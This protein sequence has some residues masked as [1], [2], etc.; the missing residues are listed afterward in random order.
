MKFLFISL[1]TALVGMGNLANA[2]S[3]L[4]SEAVV[5]TDRT[6]ARLIA[7]APNGIQ[8]GADVRVGLLLKH[9]PEWHTYWK[10]SGES[11]LPTEISW[12]LPAGSSAGPLQ[13]PTPK[14]FKLGPLGNYG[15]D[16]Q[17]LLSSVITVTQTPTGSVWPLT[18]AA[19]WLACRAECVPE[20]AELSL[21]L[22]LNRPSVSDRAQFESAQSQWPKELDLDA[23]MRVIDGALELRVKGVPE[24]WAGQPLDVFPETPN[25]IVAGSEAKGQWAGPQYVI[26][27]PL[28]PDREAS[29]DQVNWV[30]AQADVAHG[31]PAPTGM[32][33]QAHIQGAWPPVQSVELNP[34]LAQALARPTAPAGFSWWYAMILAFLGGVLLNLM[35]C[36]FPVLA[37]KVLAIAQSDDLRTHR[38]SGLA[39][40]LGVVVSFCA[41]AALLFGLRAGGAAIGWGF[42]LQE[43]SVIA[44]LAVLF[45]LIG[46][47]LA[48]LFEFS[49]SGPGR[50]AGLR[51]RHPAMDALWS[52]VLATAVASP[53][54]APFM[55]AALGYA[56][57]Q[58]AGVGIA[59]FGAVGLGM[60]SPFLILSW[61]P[62]L[63]RWL[64]GPG[65][66]MVHFKQFMA[67]PMFATVVWLIWVIGQQGGINASA[68]L[69]M[70]LLCTALWLWAWQLATP[71]RTAWRWLG[72][73][74][75]I[76]AAWTLTP[77]IATAPA[78]PV[79]AAGWSP[80]SAQ[81]EQ[82]ARE[83]GRR[84]FV[85]F[86][87]A[88]CVT[89]QVNELGALS[90]ARVEQAFEEGNWVRLR[91][92]WTK[93]DPEISAALN[94][95]Q[96]TGV[97]TYVVYHPNRPPEILTE[98]L[99]VDQIL[100][101]ITPR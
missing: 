75:L 36:V 63:S 15:Y 57:T 72:T 8:V 101:A 44:A 86:T 42:Q 83:A 73:A 32:R 5:K 31:L 80:W 60:A 47:N 22:P 98:L 68:A 65:A 52:G 50:L 48:G 9:A 10:N 51:L 38:I 6:E 28:H 85:D 71:W 37:I 4:S 93:R 43:P 100:N 12:Q 87:A 7:Y 25:L 79:V 66:W 18:M 95:L 77:A 29:P 61:M 39:Y 92:D 17:V 67:F 33:F 34:A 81:V 26:A 58:P 20:S 99:T 82:Q 88:W 46:L 21:A 56:I 49:F 13:W 40:T 64:P 97:P 14:K 70:L 45:T 27:L 11:G 90:D 89:C 16:G 30:L 55:G 69:L 53:C 41:L 2:Q 62:A 94:Q 1:V 24:P 96:R 54:T 35:P 76:G 19:N 3:W 59:L 23:T 78:N 74:V 84:V 91:A